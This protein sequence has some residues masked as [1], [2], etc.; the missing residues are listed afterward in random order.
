MAEVK[1]NGNNFE[2]YEDDKKAGLLNFQK[3]DD[4]TIEIIHTEVDEA[5][6]GKGLGKELVKAAVNY[7]KEN[8]Y[9]IIASCTYA[10]KVIDKTPEFQEVL[11]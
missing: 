5:F 2:L 11:K 7:A 10:K 8:N 6:G 4:N 1:Q 3:T 9:K